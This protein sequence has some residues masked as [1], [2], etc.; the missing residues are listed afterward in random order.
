M[1][2]PRSPNP[3]TTQLNVRV[4]AEEAEDLKIL[5]FVSGESTATLLRRLL[6]RE[7]ELARRHSEFGE[8]KAARQS[9]QAQ[10]DAAVHDIR[11]ARTRR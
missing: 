3:K 5:E 8:A 9:F 6:D 4:T 1:A 7:L 2:R 11:D 10:Q